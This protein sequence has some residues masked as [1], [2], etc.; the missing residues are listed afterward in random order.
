MCPVVDLKG[1]EMR[2]DPPPGLLDLKRV[3]E[4]E[5]APAPARARRGA[6]GAPAAAIGAGA[7]GGPAAEGGRGERAAERPKAELESKEGSAAAE[8]PKRPKKPTPGAFG[9]RPT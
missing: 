7:G 9:R 6:D 8:R 3:V 2:I 1:G 5:E 4:R